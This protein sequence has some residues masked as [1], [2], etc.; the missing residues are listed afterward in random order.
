MKYIRKYVKF[1]E[2]ETMVSKTTTQKPLR[3]KSEYAT[4]GDVLNR[5]NEIYKSLPSEE[6][7]EINSYF[8]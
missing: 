8:K 4:S 1:F 3:K 7:E 6:Q 2:N 5:F